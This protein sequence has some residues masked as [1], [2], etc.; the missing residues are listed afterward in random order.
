M[1]TSKSNE[2][3]GLP[4]PDLD[5]RGLFQVLP[6]RYIIV[7]ANDPEFTF[8]EV[9][10]AHSAMTGVPREKIIGRPFFEVFPDVSEKFKRTGVSDMRRALQEVIATRQAH[11][12]EAFRY[13]IPDANGEFVER[14]WRPTHYP[15]LDKSGK[16]A[17]ILQ[18]SYDVTEELASAR[19]LQ[20]TRQQLSDALAIGKVGSWL[21]EVEQNRVVMSETLAG[22][23]GIDPADA[24]RG[25]PLDAFT[26]AI[27][28]EDR[29]RVLNEI[30]MAVQKGKRFESEYRLVSAKG[31]V[32]WV[33][34][35]GRLE[36]GKGGHT[37]RMS[38]VIV[39][40]T[41]RHTL[42]S[43]IEAARI[44][45]ELSVREAELLQK[46]NEELESINRTKDE[47][48][49]L[50]SHQLRT[51][52][53]AVKQYIGMVLQGYV[54]EVSDMQT[55][56]LE[57]AFESNERQIQI[58]NQILNAARVDT[59]RLIMTRAPLD[60]RS[61]LRGIV[62]EMR[63]GIEQQGHALVA[64]LDGKPLPVEADAG[65]LRMAIENVIHNASV[66]TP[67]PGT[68]TVEVRRVGKQ[69]H[70]AITDTG[71]GIR[72]ADIPRLFEKFSRIHN[73]LSVQAGGSGI[74]L[75]LTAEIVRLHGG[76]VE[77][78]SKLDHGTTF[79]IILPLQPA[80]T[81]ANNDKNEN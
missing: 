22:L 50:A 32:S 30:D 73:S 78:S 43:Q 33:L 20:E 60:V 2:S 27:H 65:Y 75:Y 9:N 25:L 11:T 10:E 34:A 45:E 4:V 61:Q 69:V 56:M 74:G 44:R 39:D 28:P 71:V 77:V 14:Y 47:F 46:R 52:A 57:K 1:R 81:T 41:E 23:F 8:V 24:L 21:W 16:V 68:I 58:I 49:A 67:V 53:T 48:V 40:I 3:H 35:R 17:F 54:G 18:W 37:S 55:D 36:I 7:R 51:P 26:Q 80:A 72:K 5:Y 79:T 62:D 76:S 59:G 31:R 66:Y 13:D 64:T 6:E 38:G 63:P 19:E 15:L 42:E 29:P 70:I 12:L